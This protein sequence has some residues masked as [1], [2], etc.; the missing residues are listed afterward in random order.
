MHQ[1]EQLWCFEN[2]PN[3]A[4]KYNTKFKTLPHLQIA[5]GLCDY[6]EPPYDRGNQYMTT[7]V[8]RVRGGGPGRSLQGAPKITKLMVQIGQL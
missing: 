1:I 7:V 8:A 2:V 6:R 5:R 3:H 4:Q